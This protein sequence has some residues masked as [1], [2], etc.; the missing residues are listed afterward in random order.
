[1]RSNKAVDM[2]AEFAHA[3]GQTHEA[4]PAR[5]AGPAQDA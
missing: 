5:A 1:M 2:L 3:I 4:A